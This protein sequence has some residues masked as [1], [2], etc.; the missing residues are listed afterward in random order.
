MLPRCGPKYGLGALECARVSSIQG[1]P[2]TGHGVPVPSRSRLYAEPPAIRH[3]QPSYHI[4]Q[5]EIKRAVDLVKEYTDLYV[6]GKV[7]VPDL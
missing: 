6:E 7:Q 4:S 5:A 3:L 2:T 1:G